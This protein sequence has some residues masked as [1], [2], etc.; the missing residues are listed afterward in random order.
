MPIAWRRCER[1]ARWVRMVHVK[2]PESHAI[3]LLVTNPKTLQRKALDIQNEIR[4]TLKAFG[5]KVGKVSRRSFEKKVCELIGDQ[6]A[7]SETADSAI[8]PC[9]PGSQISIVQRVGVF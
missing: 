1:I 5:L 2:S 7:Q 9:S 3:R 8:E 4:G 6:Q